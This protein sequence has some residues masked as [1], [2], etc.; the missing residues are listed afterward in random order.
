MTSRFPASMD[1][2]GYNAPS[3]IECDIYDLVV[4]GTLP[5]ELEGSWYRS[6]PDPQYPPFLGDDTFLSGDGMVSRFRFE[7]GHVDLRQRYVQTARFKAERAARRSLFGRYR[8]PYTDDPSVRG[9]DRG[10]NN[11]TPIWHG[12]RLLALKEDS[13][14]VEL[15]PHTL[16]TRGPWDYQGQLR[17][18][19]MTAHTR[20]DFDTGELYF[21]GYEAGGLATRDVAYCVADRNGR[22]LREEW[23]E[24]PYCAMMH[25]F[26][27]TKEHAIFPV[28]PTTS[29]LT[30]LKAGGP[31]WIWEPD[32]D[33]FVGIMPRDGKVKDLRWFRG[34]PRSAYHFM[35]AYTEGNKVHLDFGC[36]KVNPCPFIREATGIQVRPEEMAGAFVRWTFDLSKPGERFEET[37]LGPGGDMPRA[38]DKDAMKDYQVG[39]YQTFDPT[40]GPPL[41]AGPVGAGFNTILRLEVRSGKLMSFHPDG[42]STVQEHFHVPSQTPGHEGYL[43][44]I[45]DRHAESLSELFILEAQHIEKGPVARVKVPLRLRV[46]VHGNWIPAAAV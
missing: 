4:E 15:D 5:D 22:L 26:A 16:E 11:T 34:P 3:R 40:L 13:R 30:R 28:F 43:G 46:G 19:T 25:D 23:F 32:K 33:S 2:A 21:F 10:A 41:I 9:V 12:G 24:A 29:D 7:H 39:Y 31:H 35:N 44:F 6:V 38:A 27:V 36:G 8:N 17:S 1:F 20:A 14:A 42:A 37:V 18:Q 45:V